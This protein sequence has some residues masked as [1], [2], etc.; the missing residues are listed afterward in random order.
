MRPDSYL[1]F[2]NASLGS[3]L[4]IISLFY[5]GFFGKIESLMEWYTKLRLSAVVAD[6]LILVICLILTSFVYYKLFSEYNFF[7]YLF[8][9]LSVQ[10]V[11][12]VVFAFGI[13]NLPTGMYIVDLFKRY[14]GEIGAKAI[15]GDS[16]M[17]IITTLLA[18]VFSGLS[19]DA[20]IKTL[21]G[22]SY[23]APYILFIK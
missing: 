15:L 6:T 14:I 20:S 4:I 19:F 10:I 1:T 3:D 22:L 23:M 11:H 5:A 2:L 9:F 16:I 7:K 18:H 12:D 13:Q 17:V 21:I 8:L